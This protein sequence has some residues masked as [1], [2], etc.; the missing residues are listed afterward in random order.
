MLQK[1]GDFIFLASVISN[2]CARQNVAKLG[3]FS[4]VARLI[5]RAAL[6]GMGV[7]QFL[8]SKNTHGRFQAN[9]L[10]PF[11]KPNFVISGSRAMSSP[12]RGLARRS[13]YVAIPTV[14]LLI[15]LTSPPAIAVHRLATVSRL[16]PP[17][18]GLSR[19]DLVPW[20]L[21]DVD[22]LRMSAL[23]QPE[24]RSAAL[25][26]QKRHGRRRP[27]HPICAIVCLLFA[28]SRSS[29]DRIPTAREQSVSLL[30]TLLGWLSFC[31][32]F[33]LSN[34][35][36]F[37][38]ET[39]RRYISSLCLPIARPFPI[40]CPGCGCRRTDVDEPCHTA[41][42]PEN[43]QNL[44]GNSTPTFSVR[45]VRLP[46]SLISTPRSE[47]RLQGPRRERY[48]EDLEAFD[49]GKPL[50]GFRRNQGQNRGRYISV[51]QPVDR[52]G[53][54]FAEPG[55]S[56]ACRR[57][58]SPDTRARCGLPV[59]YRNILVSQIGYRL[60]FRTNHEKVQPDYRCCSATPPWPFRYHWTERPP[61]GRTGCHFQIFVPLQELLWR[62]SRV[63][64]AWSQLRPALELFGYR[65]WR[66]KLTTAGKSA[67]FAGIVSG[68]AAGLSAGCTVA[69]A[70]RGTS[71]GMG[72]PALRRG[73]M[74]TASIF[75]VRL[76]V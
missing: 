58:R 61:H 10:G 43:V 37:A 70:V 63:P 22:N 8:A 48:A 6:G 31:I 26:T 56:G 1:N 38:R 42:N 76:P 32:S 50:R 25:L 60:D 11:V 53:L 3:H 5:C 64:R 29:A 52:L 71:R 13:S 18:S 55:F 2:S 75:L 28:H 45:K 17:R 14:G 19:S 41:E 54:T 34:L 35:P 57:D 20:H 4:T 12:H 69:I 65:C 72:Q 9:R 62:P 67:I 33:Q 24:V 47:V 15:P 7:H 30:S 74:P 40:C 46:G 27:N 39:A 68:V 21:T 16:L 49:V 44:R 59:L 66:V 51:D 23:R 36:V 73:G